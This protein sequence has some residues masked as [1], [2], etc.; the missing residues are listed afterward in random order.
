MNN[1]L[2]ENDVSAKVAIVAALA[3]AGIEYVV[4][5]PGGYTGAIYGMAAVIM[6][7]VMLALAFRVRAEQHG[8]TASK[9][10]FA[11]SILYLF[12][13]FAMLLADRLWG[14]LAAQAVSHFAA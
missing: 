3:D 1:M 2:I 10:L 8:Y 11:F 7:A 4:G 13:L 5:M 12:L 9:Q 14:G 6:G